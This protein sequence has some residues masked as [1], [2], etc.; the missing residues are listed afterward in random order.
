[1]KWCATAVEGIQLEGLIELGPTSRRQLSKSV[2]MCGSVKSIAKMSWEKRLR[3]RPIGCVS[4]NCMGAP[5]IL[6][7]LPL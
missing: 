3:I 1:M 6:R 4:K 5:R 2:M 7:K